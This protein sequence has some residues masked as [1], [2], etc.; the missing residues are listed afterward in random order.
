MIIIILLKLAYCRYTN[1]KKLFSDSYMTKPITSSVDIF[2]LQAV[3]NQ[4]IDSS[5]ANSYIVFVDG[6]YVES[7]S[8]NIDKNIPS[9]IVF[10]ALSNMMNMDHE[11]KNKLLD[12]L[13]YVPDKDEKP[14]DSFS[15][16]LVTCLN[17][18]Y[19]LILS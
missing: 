8:K 11:Y 1:V 15:S 14:R 18:V 4:Y 7:L 16:D 6:V 3:I 5:C 2:K 10:S 17:L 12:M 19:T 9:S 13:R